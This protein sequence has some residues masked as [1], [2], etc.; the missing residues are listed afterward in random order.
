MSSLQD[1]PAATM[2]LKR[3]TTIKSSGTKHYSFE[4]EACLRRTVAPAGCGS[5]RALLAGR[6]SSVLACVPDNT[7]DTHPLLEALGVLDCG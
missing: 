3:G 2:A 4:L 1:G 7:A 6:V 5:L